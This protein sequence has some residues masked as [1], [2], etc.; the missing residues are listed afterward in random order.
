MKYFSLS[1][2]VVKGTLIFIGFSTSY[3]TFMFIV[4]SVLYWAMTKNYLIYDTM[5]AILRCLT[6]F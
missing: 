5:V 1:E 2:W 6:I 3:I 4:S